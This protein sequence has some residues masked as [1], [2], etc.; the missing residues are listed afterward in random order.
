MVW[1]DPKPGFQTP[2][3]LNQWHNMDMVLV[4]EASGTDVQLFLAPDVRVDA[5]V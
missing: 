1:G 3:T 4:P 2:T 5:V